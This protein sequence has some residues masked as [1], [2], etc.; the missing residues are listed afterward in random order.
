MKIIYLDLLFII[1]FI[2]DYFLFLCS[3][4]VAGCV[5]RRKRY[6]LAALLG[7]LYAVF[8]AMPSGFYLNSA[9]AKLAVATLMSLIAFGSERYFLRCFLIFLAV[10]ASFG[11]AVW[12][13]FLLSGTTPSDEPFVSL[14]PAMLAL[15]FALCYA[16]IS[17]AFRGGIRKNDTQI[18]DM[19]ISLNSHIITLRALRDTGNCL[20]DPM[21]GKSV[22]VADSKLLR[23]LFPDCLD[24]LHLEDPGCLV[25]KISCNKAYERRFRLIPYS[26]LGNSKGLLAA[27]RP[28]SIHIDGKETDDVLIAI[29]HDLISQNGTYN[30]IF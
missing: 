23:P 10:S 26:S 4:R 20:R 22:A 19:R 18:V 2:I 8:A 21:S 13:V 11:G 3:A 28:D 15:A 14:S 9:L 30:A 5:L 25:S 27:F 6:V 1:N 7:A 17:F 24:A 29:S 16:F 12:A